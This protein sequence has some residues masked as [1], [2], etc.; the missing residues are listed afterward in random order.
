VFYRVDPAFPGLLEV[1][2]WLVRSDSESIALEPIPLRAVRK[3][4]HDV[5]FR[6]R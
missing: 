5:A 6:T 1:E 2:G 4:T 3:T